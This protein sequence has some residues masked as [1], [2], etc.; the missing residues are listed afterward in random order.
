MVSLTEVHDFGYTTCHNIS[1]HSMTAVYNHLLARYQLQ[2]NS[3]FFQLTVSIR[4]DFSAFRVIS[5]LTGV[6][7][8]D[9]LAKG[10][11]SPYLAAIWLHPKFR[12]RNTVSVDFS[13]GVHSCSHRTKVR[14]RK[15]SNTLRFSVP[16]NLAIATLFWVF[17]VVFLGQLSAF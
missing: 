3:A 8:L 17:L 15:K 2:R 13:S 5:V 14:I 10:Y 9:S 4:W 6:S 7:S 1:P 16:C 11:D 12:N